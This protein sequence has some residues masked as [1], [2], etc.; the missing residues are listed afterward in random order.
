MCQIEPTVKDF[1]GPDILTIQL[2]SHCFLDAEGMLWNHGWRVIYYHSN[3]NRQNVNILMLFPASQLLQ[4]WHKEGKWH[5][6][7][8]CTQG[9]IPELQEPEYFIM[10][11][12]YTWD[13]LERDAV[14]ILQSHTHFHFP[15]EPSV[16]FKAL[17]L[18]K[19]PWKDRLKQGKNSIS[20]DKQT[21]RNVTDLWITV[22]Q[23]Y[24][25]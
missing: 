16:S 8:D 6:H 14:S 18:Y 15:S 2:A 21:W 20:F 10:I 4:M 25:L 17:L 19:Y 11:S 24:F 12:T 23:Y 13:F 5:L 7:T 9:K 1:E 3:N 22:S